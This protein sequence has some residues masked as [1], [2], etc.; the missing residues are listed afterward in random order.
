MKKEHLENTK[1]TTRGRTSENK[2]L[3]EQTPGGQTPGE[4]LENPYRTP[5]EHLEGGHLENSLNASRKPLEGIR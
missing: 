3:G 5:G 2:R 4:H 1:K